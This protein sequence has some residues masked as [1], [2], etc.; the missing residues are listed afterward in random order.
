MEVHD[1]KKVQTNGWNYDEF[2]QAIKKGVVTEN[3]KTI[4]VY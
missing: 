4:R 3:G 2:R 1:W